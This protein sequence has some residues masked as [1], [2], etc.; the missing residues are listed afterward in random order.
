MGNFGKQKG[1]STNTDNQ[2]IGKLGK[3][4][5]QASVNNKKFDYFKKD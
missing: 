2:E 4:L 1:G 3:E 5:A